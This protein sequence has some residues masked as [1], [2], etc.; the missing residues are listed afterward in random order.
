MVEAAP[1]NLGFRRT[2]TAACPIKRTG[3]ARR[4]LPPSEKSVAARLGSH[5]DG[6][7]KVEPVGNAVSTEMDLKGAAM[8]RATAY[9]HFSELLVAAIADELAGASRTGRVSDVWQ[10]KRRTQTNFTNAG[11]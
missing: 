9:R 8:A 5:S 11:R 4:T 1:C 6:L 2:A 3:A 10:T 7:F